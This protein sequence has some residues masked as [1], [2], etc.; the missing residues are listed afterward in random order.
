MEIA[1]LKNQTLKIR[2]DEH[3]FTIMQKNF[4]LILCSFNL[5]VSSYC[6][7]SLRIFLQKIKW[8]VLHNPIYMKIN[9]LTFPQLC[10]LNFS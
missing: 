8:G 6:A 2:R 10:Y 4:S 1:I 7:F 3:D 9:L 5:I